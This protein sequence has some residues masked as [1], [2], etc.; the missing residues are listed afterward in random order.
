MPGR[1]DKLIERTCILLLILLFVGCNVGYILLP[2]LIP[3]HYIHGT[4]ENYTSKAY[5]FVLPSI[6]I[7]LY[8]V[9]SFLGK[10]A[11]ATEFEDLR[12]AELYYR[13]SIR[14]LL[15]VKLMV[16]V[17]CTIEMG[18]TVRL[19]YKEMGDPGWFATV[20]EVSLLMVPLVYYLVNLQRIKKGGGT[21][22]A[23]HGRHH[24]G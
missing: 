5:F 9:L 3:M 23:L 24:N 14:R 2:D 11:G 8:I 19:S 18:E 12:E 22:H 17:A 21:G 6:G 13:V 4:A 15:Y 7:F 20:W 10:N 1:V 16:L